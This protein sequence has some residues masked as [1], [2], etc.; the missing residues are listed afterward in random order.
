MYPLQRRVKASLVMLQN[1][2]FVPT[3]GIELPC[4]FY[5][6]DMDVH[7]FRTHVKF[8]PVKIIGRVLGF[9]SNNMEICT[10]AN[11][12]KN[13]NDNESLNRYRWSI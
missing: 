9:S 11:L 5:L 4:V 13:R 1:S 8:V 10:R 2:I 12:T 7:H 6:R 3:P